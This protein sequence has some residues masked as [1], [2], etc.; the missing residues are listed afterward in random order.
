MSGVFLS[1]RKMSLSMDWDKSAAGWDSNE[2]MISYSE[3]AFQSLSGPLVMGTTHDES[4]C[5]GFE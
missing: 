3:K 1:V 2:D 5:M 4:R